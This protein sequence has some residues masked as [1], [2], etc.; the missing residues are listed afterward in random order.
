MR[1]IF[2]PRRQ[3]PA[4][5]RHQ[6]ADRP[7]AGGPT[8]AP[9]GDLQPAHDELRLHLR[10]RQH[11]RDRSGF[12][13]HEHRARAP[14]R[15]I[16]AT[17]SRIHSVSAAP[18]PPLRAQACRRLSGRRRTGPAGRGLAGIMAGRRGLVMGVAND[19]SIAWGIAQA[20]HGTGGPKLAFSYQGEAARQARAA[21]GGDAL[22][23]STRRCR[24]T[25]R[26]S[27]R[28]IRCSNNCDGDLG[29]AS[30]SSSH[31]IAYSAKAEL[32]GRYADTTRENFQRTMLVSA[33]SFTEIAKRA[34]P[35]LR[36]GGSLLTLTFG[37][38]YPRRCR[39]TM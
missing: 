30:I 20:L 18:M 2:R 25:W 24:A 1:R 33:F 23:L 4:D 28:S 12:R 32:K 13:R 6:V 21:A 17:C 31:C 19:H 35:L 22:A 34:A 39:T 10:E 36:P 15:H 14:R 27:P 8:G 37:G 3:E 26:I 11:R 9:G 7:F 38:C 29:P 5:L 16:S